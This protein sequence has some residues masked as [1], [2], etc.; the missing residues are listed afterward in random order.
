MVYLQRIWRW[1]QRLVFEAGGGSEFLCDT[2]RY[3]H[4]GACGRR[5]RPNARRCPD[6]RR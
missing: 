3:D 6:Y 5:E 4:G 2:C 1:W